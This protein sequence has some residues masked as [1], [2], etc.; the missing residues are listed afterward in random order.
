MQPEVERPELEG[1]CRPLTR[2]P[3]TADQAEVL[4][5]RFEALGDP[6]RPR[7]S[8]LIASHKGSEACGCELTA[9]FPPSGPTISHY[10]RVLREA[11]FDRRAAMHPA[12]TL[13]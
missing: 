9:G 6:V 13:T 3:L 11:G 4:S 7:L 10:L 1:S 5:R 8:S 12:A 2:E